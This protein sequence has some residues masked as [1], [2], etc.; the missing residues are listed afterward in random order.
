MALPFLNS[1][2]RKKRTQVMAV[3]LGSR[4]TKA[5][6]LERRGE[7]LALS[8][9]A[10]L[11]APIYD[12]KFSAD[13]LSDHLRSVAEALGNPTKL[14]TLAL[15]L[16]DAVVRQVELPQIPVSEMRLV[17]RNNSKAY[18][19]QDLPNYVFDCYIFPPRQ[20]AGKPA[21]A[22]K[23][24]GMTKL[25]VL[26]AGAKQSVLNDYQMAI[27]NAGLT[28]DC[29]VP[30]LLGPVNAF[31]LAL[32]QVF[33]NES[34]ALVDIG[35]KQTSICI[36]DRGELVLSRVVNIGGD[37]L[38]TDLAQ[39]MKSTYAEAEGAKV[40]MSPEAKSAIEM[41]VLPLGREL[42]ASLDFFEHQQDRPV[43]QVYMSGGT[44]QSEMILQMLHSEMIVECKTWNPT[45]FL[46]LALPGQQAV[47]IDHVGPQLTVAVGVALA[48]F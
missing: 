14:I 32:P 12:K 18:M 17:L 41:Q 15:G 25:K 27:K 8:R 23:P 24:T 39:A 16:D 26:A 43:S 20:D 7:L 34:V 4:T 3:D 35:F 13:L 40:G 6:L 21:E 2:S 28:A 11:D 47:E 46:Q 9:Y 44:A 31:E 42:R 19:Q 22:P 29:I 10:L 36:L 38:T 48:A 5:V 37:K 30:G 33:A 45:G 1:S